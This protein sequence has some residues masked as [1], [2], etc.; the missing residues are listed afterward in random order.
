MNYQPQLNNIRMGLNEALN[1]YSNEICYLT[2]R[3]GTTVE[4]IPEM[5][6]INDQLQNEMNENEF[7]EDG[8][9]GNF[10]DFN[11]QQMIVNHPAALRGRGQN[12]NIGKS[13]RK[14]VLKSTNGKEK[15]TKVRAKGKLRNFK[16]L[17]NFTENNDFLQCGNCK[18]FFS[19]DDEGNENENTNNSSQPQTP[20]KQHIQNTSKKN[21]QQVSP[22][23]QKYPQNE[24]MGYQP[25]SNQAHQGF[26]QFYQIKI[27]QNQRPQQ[28]YYQQIPSNQQKSPGQKKGRIPTGY[29]QPMATQF[30][31]QIQ[32]I[33]RARKKNSSNTNRY[34]LNENYYIDQN[35]SAEENYYY[36][37][38]AKKHVSEQRIYIEYPINKKASHNINS[39]NSNVVKN[40]NFGM[41]RSISSNQENPYTDNNLSEYIKTNNMGY[42]EYPSQNRKNI[43]PT[44]LK[45]GANPRMANIKMA[46]ALYQGY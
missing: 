33:F 22:Q 16:A 5:S 42:Y 9:E 14:T 12:K 3:D 18:K 24:Q 1:A 19:K 37:I 38:S 32:P 27:P 15:E 2:L 31:G 46:N 40:L 30:R 10:S 45:R 44:G 20:N 25:R 43:I 34:N 7:I 23:Q 39:S 17:I 36:P 21:Q 13:L 41:K 29:F 8:N 26:Q 28:Q 6:Y 11:Y 4:I 35:Y